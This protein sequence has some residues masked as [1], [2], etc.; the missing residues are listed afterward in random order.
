MA[1]FTVAVTSDSL[2]GFLFAG[3]M[4]LVHYNTKVCTN[5]TMY[6][7]MKLVPDIPVPE[8]IPALFRKKITIGII[9]TSGTFAAVVTAIDVKLFNDMSTDIGDTSGKFCRCWCH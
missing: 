3:E 4:H 8:F 2:N 1:Q 7:Q 9:D 5:S 6:R